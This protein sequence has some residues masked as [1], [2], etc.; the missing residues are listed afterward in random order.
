MGLCSAFSHSP[1]HIQTS[2]SW[3]DER[4]RCQTMQSTIYS[5][6]NSLASK[7]VMRAINPVPV[8]LL[9]KPA[10]VSRWELLGILQDFEEVVEPGNT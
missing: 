6:K 5:A 2:K 9:W 7:R 4:N 3:L 1:D 8:I 10:M